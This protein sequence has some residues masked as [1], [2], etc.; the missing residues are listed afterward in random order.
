[1][2]APAATVTLAGADTV[3]ALEVVPM[4]TTAPPDG[5]GAV[6]VTVH[7][8]DPGPVKDVGAQENADSFGVT[9]GLFIVTV[10][11]DAVIGRAAAAPEAAAALAT[12]IA[13]D[14]DDVVLETLKLAVAIAPVEIAVEFRPLTRHVY[15]PEPAELHCTVFPAPEADGP[16]ATDTPVKSPGANENVH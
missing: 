6:R 8:V 15:L 1:M 5:A 2:V 4:D 7:W 10:V 12:P 3:A 11:P 14:V 9:T 13:L 16:A